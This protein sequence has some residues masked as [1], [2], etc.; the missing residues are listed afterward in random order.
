MSN[1]L[2]NS[3]SSLLAGVIAI[4]G[5]FSTMAA[6]EPKLVHLSKEGSGRATA[7]LESPKI[8]SFEDKTHVVWL[9]SPKQGFRIRMRTLDQTSGSWSETYEVGEAY[10]NHGGPALTVDEE[11]YLH[12]VY[13]SHHHP[14]RYRRSLR[15]NDGSAWTEFE[16]FGE[17]LTYPALVV[18]ADG[19]LIL[20]ARRSYDDRPWELEMWQRAPGE[21]W[22]RHAALL[23]ARYT[24]YAQ[25]AAALA[26]GRIM[27]LSTFQPAFM[28]CPPPWPKLR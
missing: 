14:L 13:Y 7:Y 12:L 23:R 5:F 8:I 18:G 11:G 17:H 28:K 20:V 10:N 25:F 3:L 6:A 21:E 9:D 19:T 24:G 1:M 15:P 2:K 27:A 26:W 4:C 22:R 16:A